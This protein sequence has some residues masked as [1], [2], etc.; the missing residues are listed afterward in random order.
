MANTLNIPNSPFVDISTGYVSREW[1][2]WIINPKFLTLNISTALGATSGG[3]GQ[4][5]YITGDLLYASASDTLSRLADVATGNALISGGVSL[6]PF[7]GKINL[8]NTV[9]GVLHPLNGGTGVANTGTITI[10]D[11]FKI[12]G[13]F[14]LTINLTGPTSI[15]FPSFGSFVG[16]PI[17]STDNAV[18]RFNGTSG[19]LIQDSEVIIDDSGN[20]TASS[21]YTEGIYGAEVAPALTSGNWTVTSPGWDFGTGPA[22]LAKDVDAVVLHASAVS[23]AAVTSGVVYKFVF[24]VTSISTSTVFTYSVG[25]GLG[26]NTPISATGTYTD[27]ITTIN[28]T[29]IT[30]ASLLGPGFNTNDYMSRITISSLS[31]MEITTGTGDLSVDGASDFRSAATFHG[32]INFGGFTATGSGTIEGSL[33]LPNPSGF[34]GT[35]ISNGEGV[36]YFGAGFAKPLQIGAYVLIQP[37]TDS[38]PALDVYSY[39]EAQP[40]IAGR[41]TASDP[42]NY[43]LVLVAASAQTER[44]LRIYDSTNNTLG[45]ID[46]IGNFATRNNTISNPGYYFTDDVHTG[47]GYVGSTGSSNLLLYCDGTLSLALTDNLKNFRIPA[48]YTYSWSSANAN[49]MSPDTG[50]SR[51]TNGTIGVGN[52]TPGDVGGSIQMARLQIV[53]GTNAF[54]GT[55]TLS[56]GAA[57]IATTAVTSG[58]FVFLTD[59]G[60]SLTNVGALSVTSKT[61]GTGFTVGSTNILDTSTFNW[62]VVN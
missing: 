1:L 27:Y 58:S 12:N 11:D 28:T 52:G 51:L 10:G 34:N 16:G 50:L 54:I 19:A 42:A 36:S 13:D 47:V 32:P 37:G 20:V 44:L 45:W 8:A 31:L 21:L 24:T 40:T 30:F 35:F 41:F 23:N 6:A 14:P 62:L 25:G 53:T 55:G 9:S 56:G 49:N 15:T 29:G 39:N 59:T 5:G 60:A 22:T 26:T 43:A 48:N 7:W 46:N 18:A 17:S 61:A 2:Q 57:T 33:S 4:S 38:F 3:T